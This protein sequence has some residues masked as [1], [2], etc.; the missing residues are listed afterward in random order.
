MFAGGLGEGEADEGDGKI[1]PAVGIGAAKGSERR[2]SEG[3]M[4]KP[5]AERVLVREAETVVDRGDVDMWRVLV[6]YY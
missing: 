2:G 1:K 4:D 3:R 5:P 6:A